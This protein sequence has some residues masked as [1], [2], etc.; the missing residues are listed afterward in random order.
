[1]VG[2]IVHR[3]HLRRLLYTLRDIA[4]VGLKL[5]ELTANIQVADDQVERLPG[6]NPPHAM[7]EAHR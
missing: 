4:P 2:D 6:D 7:D 5:K 3:L 1:M